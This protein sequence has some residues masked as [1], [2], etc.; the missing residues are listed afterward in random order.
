MMAGMRRLLFSAVAVL[1]VAAAPASATP[2]FSIE[3]RPTTP[4][5][6]LP[7]RVQST[8][9]I[10]GSGQEERFR[11]RTLRPVR[12]AGAIRVA[13]ETAVGPGV[14]QCPG[15]WQ[16][17]HRA[18]ASSGRFD[19]DVVMAPTGT[20]TVTGVD[21]LVRAPWTGEDELGLAFEIVPHFE[22]AP[23]TL[24]G[25]PMTITGEP[26]RYLGP[27]GVQ[28][29][30]A[31]TSQ[32]IVATTTPIINNGRIVLRARRGSS[33]VPVATLPVRDGIVSVR[34]RAPRNGR[35][36]VYAQFRTGSRSNYADDASEC[37]LIVTAR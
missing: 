28:I 9:T 23:T 30:L 6:K 27:L 1:L 32:L 24:A 31:T 36:E 16:R 20:A 4:L 5:T 25:A 2:G 15:K 35:W 18:H 10:T 11:V 34:W 33:S 26:L 37:G 7:A 22:G 29:R 3:H 12:F 8:L 19:Y 14:A 17:F 13:R 21:S